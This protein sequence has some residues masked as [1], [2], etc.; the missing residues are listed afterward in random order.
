MVAIRFMN[1]TPTLIHSA[2]LPDAPAPF[3]TSGA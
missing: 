2:A 3:I 1:P